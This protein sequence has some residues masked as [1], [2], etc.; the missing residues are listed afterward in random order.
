M[1]TIG[2]RISSE[3]EEVLEKLLEKRGNTKSEQVRIA[4]DNYLNLYNTVQQGNILAILP[5]GEIEQL[6][7]VLAELEELKKHSNAT[8]G[9]ISKLINAYE[10]KLLE[11]LQE[12]YPDSYGYHLGKR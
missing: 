8:R 10:F 9:I 3:K 12:K 1:G 11:K 7:N 5:A 2:V 6:R 4:I